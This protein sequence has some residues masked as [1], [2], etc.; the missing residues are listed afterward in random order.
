V[1]VRDLA[2]A[3][4]EAGLD[5]F[6]AV[7]AEGNWLATEAPIDRPEVRARWL[8]LVGSGE[9]TILVAEDG[10]SLVGL[11]AVAGRTDPEFGM[12]VRADR[13]RQGVGEA[14]L[15]ASVAWARARG[16]RELVLH[17]FVHNEAAI[18]LYRKHGFEERPIPHLSRRRRGVE[19]REA[20]R[21]AKGLGAPH[22]A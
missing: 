10:G 22:L 21:M 17:V 19:R 9:G 11:C 7:A 6:E 16:A 5:L 8:D 4:L 18:A 2:E 14:L 13:R 20:I 12:L 1:R 15:V 3:D